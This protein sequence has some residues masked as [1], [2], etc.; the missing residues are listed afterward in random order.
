MCGVNLKETVLFIIFILSGF[1][2]IKCQERKIS[3]TFMIINVSKVSVHV[4]F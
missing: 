2:T 1:K 3:E 4:H